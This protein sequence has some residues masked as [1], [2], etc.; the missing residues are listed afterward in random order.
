MSFLY[1]RTISIV[2]PGVQ[3]GAGNQ[4]YLGE[5]PSTET[6]VVSG[7]SCSIQQKK[8]GRNPDASLPG[9]IAKRSMWRI[10]IPLNAVALG[11]IQD[12]D[13]VI[14]DLGIRYQVG[15]PYWNSLGYN[16][17]AEKLET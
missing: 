3:S 14:D 2:R 10:F 1:P 4:G 9:D 8:E 5:M 15:A 12:R 7:I 6:A 17:L 11:V 16:L 13:I